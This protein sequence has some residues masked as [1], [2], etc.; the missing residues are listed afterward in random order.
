MR[1]E[2]F[3]WCYGGVKFERIRVGMSKKFKVDI[4]GA[5]RDDLWCRGIVEERGEGRMVKRMRENVKD[6][7]EDVIVSKRVKNEGMV[8]RQR[9]GRER[10]EEEG[11]LLG[12][13]I[14]ANRDGLMMFQREWGMMVVCGMSWGYVYKTGYSFSFRDEWQ[15]VG[16]FQLGGGDVVGQMM[17][18]INGGMTHRTKE[19]KVRQK[20]LGV[21]RRVRVVN[22]GK[23]RKSTG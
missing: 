16:Y 8:E 13:M 15:E 4:T 3:M 11:R 1:Y 10:L 21:R 2:W 20:L 9:R 17:M 14:L 23:K 5:L 18:A 12:F 19:H 22:V 6:Y 7:L